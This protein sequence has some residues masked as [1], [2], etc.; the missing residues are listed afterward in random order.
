MASTPESTSPISTARTTQ[1]AAQA[2]PAPP[3][4]RSSSLTTAASAALTP[5]GVPGL[6]PQTAEAVPPPARTPGQPTP[7]EASFTGNHTSDRDARKQMLIAGTAIGVGGVM[8]VVIGSVYGLEARSRNQDSK[9]YCNGDDCQPMGKD[10]R[11]TALS[12]ARVST[13]LFVTG[14]AL[15]A[16]GLFFLVRAPP[17]GAEP[18]SASLGGVRGPGLEGLVAALGPARASLA[19]RGRF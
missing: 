15:I 16:G 8:A 3:V 19:L 7:V 11:D 10:L 4:P 17:A 14:G 12:D 2:L 6:P 18:S 5:G 1:A 13:V 9:A